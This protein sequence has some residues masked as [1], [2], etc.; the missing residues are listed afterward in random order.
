MFVLTGQLGQAA[1]RQ[2]FTMKHL[3]N[4]ILAHGWAL[5]DPKHQQPYKYF[6]LLLLCG[7]FERAINYLAKHASDLAPAVHFALALHHHGVLRT[8]AEVRLPTGTPGVPLHASSS[9]SMRSNMN[10][11]HGR[12][13]DANAALHASPNAKLDH[14]LWLVTPELSK[15][16]QADMD[17]RLGLAAG[18]DDTSGAAGGA[19]VGVGASAGSSQELLAQEYLDLPALVQ[20]YV[21]DKLK[22]SPRRAA[23]YICM[24]LDRDSKN[25]AVVL[26]I[27]KEWV[28]S[29]DRA[30][31]ELVGRLD[32]LTP[33][34]VRRPGL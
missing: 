18:M 2:A 34:P 30:M 21:Q 5:F 6:Q 9:T 15:E 16:E 17:V 33:L 10:G 31:N 32:Q 11:A 19:G 29:S 12:H 24:L 26:D 27:L 13:R 22:T 8:P 4:M 14:F 3:A 25:K 28:L 1:G 7:R 23:D 20:T